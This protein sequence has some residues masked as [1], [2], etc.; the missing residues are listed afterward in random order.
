MRHIRVVLYDEETKSII[1]HESMPEGEFSFHSA[2]NEGLIDIFLG[3]N[4]L[5][6]EDKIYTV[7]SRRFSIDQLKM[8]ITVRRRNK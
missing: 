7:L 2:G 3:V 1:E 5:A 6:L 8:I 4:E